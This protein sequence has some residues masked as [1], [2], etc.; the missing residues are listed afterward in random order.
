MGLRT[1]YIVNIVY[2][3]TQ[4]CVC[5]VSYIRAKCVYS[6]HPFDIYLFSASCAKRRVRIEHVGAMAS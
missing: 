4:V 6:T 2:E 5:A 3:F 1:S